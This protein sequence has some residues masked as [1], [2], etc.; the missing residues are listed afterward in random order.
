M[1]LAPLF[2]SP[3]APGNANPR[4]TVD[5][6]GDIITERFGVQW[7]DVLSQIGVCEFSL[8]N[9][10]EAI[11]SLEEGQV[12]IFRLDGEEFVAWVIDNLH[13]TTVAEGEA[14]EEVTVFSGATT[15]AEL[16]KA[17]VMPAGGVVYVDTPIYVG[18]I[19][20]KPY[21][22]E[23]FFG[24]M[25]SDWDVS[26]WSAASPVTGEPV[27]YLPGGTAA[28]I[29]STADVIHVRD[30][31]TTSG[32]VKAKL[33]FAA[34]NAAHIFIDNTCVARPDDT[35]VEG[36]ATP[37]TRS[38]EFEVRDGTHTIY[39][40]VVRGAKTYS[41]IKYT[42]WEID[43]NHLLRASGTGAKVT[44]SVEVTPGYVA[45]KL[46]AEMHDRDC[47]PDWDYDFDDVDDSAGRK[48]P[49]M[50]D[51]WSCRAKDTVYAVLEKLCEGWAEMHA[52][53]QNGGRT[54]SMWVADGVTDGDSGTGTGYTPTVDVTIE[55]GVNA[56]QLI[57]ERSAVAGNSVAWE[58]N[59]GLFYAAPD[60]PPA[61]GIVEIGLD[62]SE[63]DGAQSIFVAEANL[64]PISSKELSIT[65]EFQ[66]SA[67]SEND[68]V[69][70]VQGLG[71]TCTVADWDGTPTGYRIK[72]HSGGED[73]DGNVKVRP[74][75]NS[76]R[77]TMEQRYQRWLSR[78]NNGTNDGRSASA[79]IS[80]R[81]VTDSTV[82]TPLGGL[83]FSTGGAYSIVGDRGSRR[84][85][86]EPALVIG[87]VGECDVAGASGDTDYAIEIDGSTI[88]TITFPNGSDEA[89]LTFGTPIYAD[90]TN[91]SNIECTAE[92]GHIGCSIDVIAVPI[93]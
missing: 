84:R 81:D 82:V 15:L 8:L 89:V 40:R 42:V 32:I 88:G 63:L 46:F 73:N 76:A 48:W 39:A 45:G 70:I 13:R 14:S 19:S 33:F 28:W 26:G 5:V 27:K 37:K 74:E 43:S 92:G 79:T 53:A 16:K 56:T 75:L 23:R 35:A 38:V 87:A 2:P 29:G 41:A 51:W 91:I 11:A 21:S 68:Q 4:L 10:N 83:D 30:S 54:L 58:F 6:G 93:T 59:D 72:G 55:R 18:T 61:E 71:G 66:P 17:I 50:G 60:P 85:F 7:Q 49:S 69:K 67:G 44:S 31:F 64:K 24:P 3:P 1:P 57:H 36:N 20:L 25:E 9:N 78:S 86:S 52:L 77:D 65:A 47:L 90:Q 22:G 80:S 34:T 12:V 62:L